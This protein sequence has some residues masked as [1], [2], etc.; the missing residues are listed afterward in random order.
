MTEIQAGQVADLLNARNQL[1]TAYTAAKVRRHA[2]NYLVELDQD[3][4]IACVE[5]KQVQWYQCELRH[6]SVSAA[7]ERKGLGKRLI[8]RAEQKALELGARVVQCTIRIDN[9]ASE[10]V[11]RRSGYRETCRFFNAET[12]R[13][14]GVWQKVLSRRAEPASATDRSGE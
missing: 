1:Q 7:H 8:M 3:A 9:E 13:D 5:I 2:D 10:Q 12:D 14:V 6:L 4:V 11:F